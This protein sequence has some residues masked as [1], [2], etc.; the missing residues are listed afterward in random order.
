MS[1]CRSQESR[2]QGKGWHRRRVLK[3]DLVPFDERLVTAVSQWLGG[4]RF[5][6]WNRT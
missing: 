4:G 6:Y 2:R 3:E 1:K 5:V